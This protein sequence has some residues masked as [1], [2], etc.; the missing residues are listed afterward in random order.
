[1]SRAPYP[2]LYRVF[3]ALVAS[4]SPV[5]KAIIWGWY[6]TISIV[7][8]GSVPF[9]NYGYAPIDSVA[10]PVELQPEDRTHHYSIELYRRVACAVDLRDKDVLEV[11]CGRGGGASFVARYLGPRSVTGLDFSGRAIAF[12]R[13][14]YRSDG[15]SFRQGDAESLPFADN[16]FD[17][18]L[19]VESSHC[20]NSME[21]FLNEVTRVLRP[22][23]HF[24]FADI[25]LRE[26]VPRLHEQLRASGLRVLEEECITPNVLR[27]LELDSERKLA[28]IERSTAP[29]VLRGR[30]RHF[31][32]LK[33]S[34]V[35][36]MFQAGEW[37][38]M[39]FAL[40]KV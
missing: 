37:Q 12:C 31:A 6:Q 40:Q 38:Y 23:G 34:Q 16:S 13:Q 1:M 8:K 18:V 19:N 14:Q 7:D 30:F 28:L 29:E 22:G 24:L 5:R 36:R 15:L 39:R 25:R 9:M 26:A 3:D 2:L 17:A 11:G 21:R 27:A 20:Y 35:Y 33:G 4:P 32:G 10:P